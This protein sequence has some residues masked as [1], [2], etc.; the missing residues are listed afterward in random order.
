MTLAHELIGK[1]ENRGQGRTQNNENLL[2]ARPHPSSRVP[3]PNVG[4]KLF[5]VRYQLKKLIDIKIS[6]QKGKFPIDGNILLGY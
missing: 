5:F 3:K 4:A 2:A 6:S 1:T